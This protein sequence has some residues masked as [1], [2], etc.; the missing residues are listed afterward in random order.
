[1]LTSKE[2]EIDELIEK[3]KTQGY[4][5]FLSLFSSGFQYASTVFVNS[6]LQGQYFLGDQ[7]KKSLSMNDINL[8][9]ASTGTLQNSATA[10]NLPTSKPPQTIDE[11]EHEDTGIYL[12]VALRAR[13]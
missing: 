11:D 3:T 4:N 10:T 8:S 7:L 9:S 1:M 2:K 12:F 5:T 13:I 6:A